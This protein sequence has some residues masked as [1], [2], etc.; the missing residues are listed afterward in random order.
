MEAR[1]EVMFPSQKVCSE[2]LLEGRTISPPVAGPSNVCVVCIRSGSTTIQSTS[3]HDGVLK[4]GARPYNLF[5]SIRN[6]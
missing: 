6:C 1:C 2:K 4:V 3:D 5:A